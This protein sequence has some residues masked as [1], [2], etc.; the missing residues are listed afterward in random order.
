MT[1]QRALKIAAVCMAATLAGT[2][3][4][5]G[6]FPVKAEETTEE[7]VESV[8]QELTDAILNRS[9]DGAVGKDET[10][11]V[12]ANADGSTQEVI[13]SDWLKNGEAEDV[14]EDASDLSDIENVKGTE[15]YSGSGD[16]MLWQANGADIYYQ[17]TTDKQL[18]VDVKI[19]YQLDGKEIAPEDLA[20]KSGKV[21]IRFDYTNNEKKTVKIDGNDKDIYVPFM[22][23]SGMILDNEKFTDIEVTNG[24]VISE[25][26]HSIVMGLAMP[27]LEESLSLP[28]KLDV[29]IP[30]YVEVTANVTDFSLEMTITAAMTDMLSDMDFDDEQLNDLDDLDELRD[31]LDDLTDASGQLVDGTVQVSDGAK[32]L[33]DGAGQIGSGVEQ[34][35][36]GTNTLQKAF[37]G[38]EGAVTGAKSLASGA[39]QVSDGAKTL[40]SSVNTLNTGAKSVSDGADSVSTGASTLSKG[41]DSLKKGVSAVLTGA[42]T[43]NTGLGQLST[44]AKELSEGAENLD[45]GLDA[46]ISS[47]KKLSTELGNSY[48]AAVKAE[49]EAKA[50]CEA[51]GIDAESNVN[52]AAAKAARQTLE[53]IIG[54]MDPTLSEKL[55]ALAAGSD[56]LKSGVASAS[57]NID[58]LYEGSKTLKS[59][60][61]TVSSGTDTLASG[62]SE[63]ATGASTLATGASTLS[64]GTQEL[65]KGTTTLSTG[66]KSVSTGATALSKGV[67]KIYT[68]VKTVNSNMGSLKLGVK[69]LMGGTGKLYLGAVEL[70][71][72]MAE[73]DKEGVS[74]LTDKLTGV[75]DEYDITALKERV[76]ETLDAGKEYTIFTDAADGISTSVKFIYKTEGIG[77]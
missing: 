27:G 58:K 8:E 51:A 17:G 22:M 15:T 32:D 1:K 60:I 2:T 7:T 49:Q 23:V 38:E 42:T 64:K 70:K 67:K 55:D 75:L 5:I 35:A 61:E 76:Q 11:Y 52:Y 19:S 14:L 29:D 34:L 57:A 65:K 77:E 48:A 66:A 26:N 18:P 53:Q 54:Q 25:G 41:A 3:T 44:G 37:E 39:K 47:V 12:I 68:G 31:K 30:E 62:A 33:D 59:G 69:E 50:A 43:L 36:A 24:K 6:G 72:G 16:S 46:L 10:V 4:F 20:G 28:E 63:L 71:D 56:Q 45:A 40:E 74:T 13:V 73:F 9:G 21:T